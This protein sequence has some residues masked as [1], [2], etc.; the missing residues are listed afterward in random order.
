M[1]RSQSILKAQLEKDLVRLVKIL[2]QDMHD[3]LRVIIFRDDD[4]DVM[5]LIH[6]DMISRT[7]F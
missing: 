7:Q 1:S 6:N 3:Q 4:Q 2:D 5:Y